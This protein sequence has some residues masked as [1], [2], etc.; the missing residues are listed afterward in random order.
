MAGFMALSV[1]RNSVSALKSGEGDTILGPSEKAD[2]SHWN[3]LALSKGPNKVLPWPHLKTQK[4]PVSRT[5]FFFL[6]VYN[7]ER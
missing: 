5:L 7:S 2:L 1:V 6:F 4:D 3:R